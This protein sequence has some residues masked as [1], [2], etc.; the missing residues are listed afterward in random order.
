[1]ISKTT[2]A[3]NSLVSLVKNSGQVTLAFLPLSSFTLLFDI[4]HNSFSTITFCS[5]LLA[6][7]STSLTSPKIEIPIVFVN[8][9]CHHP[10]RAMHNL[11]PTIHFAYFDFEYSLFTFNSCNIVFRFHRSHPI[12]CHY[13]LL[14]LALFHTSTSSNDASR[15]VS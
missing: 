6:T 9:H 15:H 4:I 11:Q 14:T 5:I 10:S 8:H 7:L 12:V 3:L 1:M 13:L 2:R